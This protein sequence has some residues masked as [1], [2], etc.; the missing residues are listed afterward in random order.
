MSGFCRIRPAWG[1]GAQW[2][3][4]LACAGMAPMAA[5]QAEG[6][7][8][9]TVQI[10]VPYPPGGLTDGLVRQV[11]TELGQKWKQSVVV[12]NRGGAGTTIGTAQVAR[13]DADGHT[14][15]FTSTGFVTNQILMKSLPY[16]SDSLAPVAMGGTAPNVLYVHPSLPVH[17][18][19]GLVAYAKAK[20]GELRFAS[21]GNGSSPHLTAELLASEAGISILHVPYKGAG[22]A[23]NDLLA[24]HVNA[25]FHFPASLAQVKQG[26]LRAIAVAADA[27]LAEAPELTTF[28]QAGLP[29]VVSGSWF[30]FFAPA[31][32]P[33]AVKDQIHRDVAQALQAPHVQRYMRD[34]GLVD[35]GMSRA[36]FAAFIGNE[37]AKWE[38]VIKARNIRVE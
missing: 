22:P 2:V 27:R 31:A 15:L 33:D 37:R 18:V 13:A 25:M 6:F 8:T 24:G 9:R 11:A 19:A 30:G 7:P 23:L 4:A 10:V 16:E 3:V 17:D 35:A 21:T 38:R 29:G 28:A 5:V 20:P 34:A 32:T 14:L 36:Q 26:K 1:R 12:E